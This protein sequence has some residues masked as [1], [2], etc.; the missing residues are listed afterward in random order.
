MH[1][2]ND[3]TFIQAIALLIILIAC[4]A[5]PACSST[6]DNPI[7]AREAQERNIRY[8]NCL[9]Q[10]RGGRMGKEVYVRVHG[11]LYKDIDY[12]MYVRSL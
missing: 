8:R 10:L 3:N 5:T 1:S 11:E 2:I 7:A 4:S 6:P 9:L 12:C